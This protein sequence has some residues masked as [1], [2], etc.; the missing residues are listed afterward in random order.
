LLAGG[1][2]DLPERQQTMRG[3]ISWSYDLLPLDQQILLARMSVFAG[4]SFFEAAE[5]V[6]G[7]APS[8]DLDNGS[9][10]SM[11]PEVDVFEGIAALV[12]HSL[13]RQDEIDGD[14]RFTMLETVREFGLERLAE[15]GLDAELRRRHA[16][17]FLNLAEEAAPELTGPAQGQW[18]RR[19]DTDHDN[20][21]SA[22]TWAL[23]AGEPETA[24]R[25]GRALNGYWRLRGH[26]TEG[27]TWLERALA[28]DG[29][30]E[31]SLTGRVLGGLGNLSNELG[32]YARARSAYEESLAI[33]RELGDRWFTAAVLAN[34]GQLA[35]NEGDFPQAKALLGE[36]LVIWRELGD[37]REYARVLHNLGEVAHNEGDLL[38]AHRLH[39]EALAIRRSLRDV[40]GAAYST[41]A[42]AHVLHHQ[43]KH[44]AAAELLHHGVKDFREIGDRLG[45]AL[46]LGRLADLAREGGRQ[47]EAAQHFA[48]SLKLL[49]EIGAQLSV[50]RLEGVAALARDRDHAERAARLLAAATS[51]RETI[52]HPLPPVAHDHQ[53]Q[54]L[55]ELRARLGE[56]AFSAAWESGRHVLPEEAIEDAI[57][58]A[59]TAS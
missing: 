55:D 47:E 14:A 58:E 19:L 42:L 18:L 3:A 25:L 45:L 23:E 56:A 31:R 28:L 36:S 46:A 21:R 51:I 57:N 10:G 33:W 38:E 11:L 12:E 32:D 43:G 49:R 5:A 39:Q 9:G 6:C 8:G 1:A 29:E 4:G 50:E 20:L 37:K 22:L 54:M 52:G 53:R 27:R 2:R 34:L 40:S 24:L 41:S 30:V 16:G 44:D 17:F 48:E 7:G 15:R 13:L 59:T 26:L 35:R